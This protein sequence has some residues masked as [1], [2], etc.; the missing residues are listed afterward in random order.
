MLWDKSKAAAHKMGE[1]SLIGKSGSSGDSTIDSWV[2][3]S[4]GQLID[5]DIVQRDADPV[6]TSRKKTSLTTMVSMSC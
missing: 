2:S 5:D 4:M 6:T 3:E 1:S